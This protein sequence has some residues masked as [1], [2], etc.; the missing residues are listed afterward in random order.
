MDIKRLQKL[1]VKQLFSSRDGPHK[2]YIQPIISPPEWNEVI[3]KF[4]SPSTGPKTH[5]IL[6]CGPKSSGKST[7]ARLLTNKLISTFL[8]AINETEPAKITGIAF[9]DLDPGQ[10]EYSIPGTLS[11]IHLQEYNFG[12]PFT[13]PTPG[14]KSRVICSHSIGAVSPSLDPCL[15]LACAVNL[16]AHYRNLLSNVPNCPL[17]INTP[18]WVLGTGLEILVNLITHIRPTEVIYLSQEGPFEV[19]ER[20][21]EAAKP[22][23]VITLPSQISEYTT[24][25]AA[26]LRTM[27][28]MSYFHLAPAR[29]NGLAWSGLPLTFIPPWE[30]RYSGDNSGMLGVMCYGEQPPAALLADTINGS[31]VTVVVIDNIA[32]IPGWNCEGQELDNDRPSEMMD[33]LV[34]AEIRTFHSDSIH[35]PY[36]E[37]PLILHTPNEDIPYFN[38]GNA[39]VLDP[40]YSHSI[41]LALVRGIDIAR[42]RLQLLTPIS[43][44]VIEEINEAGKSVV[45]VSGKLDTPGWAYIEEL[46]QKTLKEKIARKQDNE[47][48]DIHEDDDEEYVEETK[49]EMDGPVDRN[50]Y[51]SSQN[52]PWVDRLE[53]SQGRGIGS[54]VWRVRRDLGRKEDRG[55]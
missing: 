15:Y 8:E 5:S 48:M 43:P 4:T 47:T 46:T 55:D 54:R 52:A 25:T 31:L 9:L 16:F 27:Q 37:N 2:A 23:P 49:E 33:T 10:P 34:D 17:V 18:G 38:P 1:N 51:D 30:I 26:H 12:P 40:N 42:R 45:L 7:F 32:A 36:L 44:T 28:S 39:I 35:P 29:K 14:P 19:V 21:R 3:A 24:R 11:L 20:L 13:H 41:G 22:T 50:P 6:I 53:G